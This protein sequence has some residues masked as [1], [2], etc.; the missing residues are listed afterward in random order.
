MQIH[1]AKGEI[2]MLRNAKITLAVLTALA[3]VGLTSC[4]SV[5]TAT[6]STISL[7]ASVESNGQTTDSE[8]KTVYG[9]VTAIDGNALT[10]AIGTVNDAAGSPS[11]GTGTKETSSDNG[12]TDAT[13]AGVGSVKSDLLTMTGETI[14]LTVTDSTKYSSEAPGGNTP[15]SAPPSNSQTSGSS[16]SESVSASA[17]TLPD[18]T[19]AAAPDTSG[20]PPENS[21]TSGSASFSDIS[22]DSILKIVYNAKTSE[23]VSIAI[24][25]GQ[26]LSGA[27]GDAGSGSP[28]G[29][30]TGD[31]S[32]SQSGSP[33]ITGTG[34]YTAA[35]NASGQTITASGENESGIRIANGDA[36]TLSASSITTSGNTTSEDE[37]NFYGLNAAV[38][39]N[40][41]GSITLT[42]SSITTSGEGANA[43]F[44]YG[45]NASIRLKNVVIRTSGDS[46]RGLDA[47]FGGTVNADQADISTEGIHCASIATDRGEG[48]IHVT[49]S[50][51]TTSG[52]DS[53]AIYSTGA[54]TVSDSTLT[55]TG[56][57]A[58]VIEG[59][60]SITL[61]DCTATGYVND[62][63]MIYQSTSGDA[64]VGTGTLTM[65]GGSLT[66]KEGALFYITNTDALINLSGTT[67]SGT[68]VLI[69]AAA[70]DRWGTSGSNGGTVTMNAD[71]ETMKGDITADEISSVTLNL[72]KSTLEGTLNGANTAK[73]MSLTLDEASVW[74]VTGTSYLTDL[75]DADAT[76]S[77]II[78]N[79]N[80]IYYDASSSA[81]SWL[82]GNTIALSGG[83]QLVPA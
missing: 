79:G 72:V 18:S 23:A 5:N 12:S 54:I 38:T 28:S 73:L 60:N 35:G 7:S 42:D 53:P 65:T 52:A 78:D 57:Q 56:A 48:T 11:D 30:G 40:D 76:L 49:N 17:A 14:T 71:S 8:Q 50:K 62:G 74:N 55:A 32:G 33:S 19:A 63:V 82:G 70:T 1:E 46:A 22:T 21:N 13:F 36:L 51:A 75:T 27:P 4:S 20:T 81:N 25:G 6:G 43:V 26:G 61:T 24:L 80:T 39:V 41:N 83:G 10:I 69:N 34:A 15:P 47:T 29:S 45:E 66:A 59:K 67:L 31:P 44:A 3:M 37:S 77:N 68:G 58:M 16:S 64:S 9:K 2:D